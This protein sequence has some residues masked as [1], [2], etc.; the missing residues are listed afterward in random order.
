MRFCVLRTKLVVCNGF[1]RFH[2]LNSKLRSYYAILQRNC[3]WITKS[4]V[5]SKALIGLPEKLSKGGSGLRLE[6][7]PAMKYRDGGN[8]TFEMISSALSKLLKGV[9]VGILTYAR[10]LLQFQLV[11][12]SCHHPFPIKGAQQ[13]ENTR[14]QISLAV[15]F[16]KWSTTFLT[17]YLFCDQT[18]KK[19]T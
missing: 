10:S 3:C 1:I 17:D 19:S 18:C 11:S 2:S 12:Q 8:K 16:T 13:Q 4:L 7:M 9:R 6:L 14:R 5:E 15:L